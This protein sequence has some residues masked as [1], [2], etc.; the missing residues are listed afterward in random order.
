LI[1]AEQAMGKIFTAASGSTNNKAMDEI[2]FFVRQ[3]PNGVSEH[4]LVN[5]A[6]TRV[7]YANSIQKILEIMQQSGMIRCVA[8]D[9]RTKLRVFTSNSM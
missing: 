1:E 2:M 7:A 6:R 5:F 3:Y 8:L 4:Q 9:P